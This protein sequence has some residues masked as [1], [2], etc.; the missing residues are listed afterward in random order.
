MQNAPASQFE[1]VLGEVAKYGVVR[2]RKANRNCKNPSIKPW[3]RSS[4]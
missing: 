2:I 4:A 1:E 3:G